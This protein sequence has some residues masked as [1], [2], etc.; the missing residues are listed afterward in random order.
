MPD[1]SD[2]NTLDAAKVA[3]IHSVLDRIDT[4]LA[5]GDAEAAGEAMRLAFELC[6]EYPD[7]DSLAEKAK[8][9]HQQAA[10]LHI[11]EFELVG[12]GTYPRTTEQLLTEEQVRDSITAALK[13]GVRP[14]HINPK[15]IERAYPTRTQAVRQEVERLLSVADSVLALNLLDLAEN[16]Q[17]L[18]PG[19]ND[20]LDAL[21]QPPIYGTYEEVRDE[22][23][24]LNKEAKENNQRQPYIGYQADH[25]VRDQLHRKPGEKREDN[26]L[27]DIGFATLLHDGQVP[28]TQ[29]KYA[30]DAQVAYI[31]KCAVTGAEPTIRDAVEAAQ[32]W[33]KEIYLSGGLAIDYVRE[34]EL[35]PKGQILKAETLKSMEAGFGLHS[36]G[37]MTRREREKIAAAAAALAGYHAIRTFMDNGGS[38]K[39]K[40]RRF[41]KSAPPRVKP[42]K[43]P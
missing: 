39:D 4:G 1:Y 9:V 8:D 5:S 20:I 10:S 2:L 38:P 28:G 29:H 13:E 7:A 31:K 16:S 15:S 18:P 19:V 27:H 36:G 34:P 6:R 25:M 26:P 11:T 35:T 17:A 41:D 42:A 22:Q 32:V 40:L 12:G 30:T 3:R 24:R 23:I 14:S 21:A 33:M 43:V 37:L